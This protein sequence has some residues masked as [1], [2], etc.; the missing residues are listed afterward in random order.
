[1]MRHRRSSLVSH[2]FL[3][4][5]VLKR[6]VLIRVCPFVVVACGHHASP[7]AAIVSH[8]VFSRLELV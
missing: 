2:E 7:A 5:K 6:L 4:T 1:M 8:K 3:R